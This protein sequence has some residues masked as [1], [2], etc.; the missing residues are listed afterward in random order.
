M[1]Y[2]QFYETEFMTAIPFSRAFTVVFDF[3]D[4]NFLLKIGNEVYKYEKV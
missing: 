1:C 4:I 2:H 3:E